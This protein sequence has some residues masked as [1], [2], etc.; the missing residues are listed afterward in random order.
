MSGRLIQL[1]GVVIDLVCAVGQL[2][3]AGEEVETPFLRVESGGGFNAMAA[4]KRMQVPV[5]Y[6]GMLGTGFFAE[7]ATRAILNEG[8]SISNRHRQLLDQGTC[9]AITDSSAERSF[10]SYHGAERQVTRNALDDIEIDDQ[11]ILLLTGY[12]LYKHQSAAALLPW[13]Q[14]LRR[15]P[16]LVFDPGP[17]ISA[18][19]KEALEVVYSR[20]DWV[21]MNVKEAQHTCGLEVGSDAAQILARNREGAIVRIG[22]EGCWLSEKGSKAIHIPGFAVTSIDTNGAGDTHVGAFIAAKLLGYHPLQ[23]AQ[24]ANA[25]AALSTTKIGPATA[26]SFEVTRAF[27]KDNGIV[28]PPAAQVLSQEHELNPAQLAHL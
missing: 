28:L 9:V 14:N 20:S 22:V 8:I 11:D 1:A 26:P 12:A 23:A 18:L 10:I 19:P 27:M 21:S 2:P 7:T 5:V 4:A 17:M 3:K 16:R 6:A 13:L 15:G 25:A 24:I